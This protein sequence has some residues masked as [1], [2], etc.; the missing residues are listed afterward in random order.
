VKRLGGLLVEALRMALAQP[1]ATAVTS[2]IVAAACG[3]ILSTTGQTVAI[4]RDVLGRIDDAGTRT[5]V[6]EDTEGRADLDQGVVQRIEALAGV[7]W[8]VGFSVTR[9]AR[10]AGIGGGAAVPIRGLV[11][12]LPT[13]VSTT[14]WDRRPG[15]ALAGVDALAALGFATAAGPVQPVAVDE[16]QLA[17]VGRLSADAPLDFLNRGLLTVVAPDE[18]VMRIIVLAESTQDVPELADGIREVLDPADP[19]SVAIQ[20]SDALL[21]VRAAVRGELG[22]WGRNLVTVVLGAGLVLTALNVFGAVTARRRDFGRRRALGASRTDVLLLVTAQTVATAVAGAALG[23]AAGMAVV[24]QLI[25]TS[26]QFEFGAAIAVLA[27]IATAIA[28]LPPAIVAAY[29]D[30]VRILRVP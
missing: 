17:V 23:V 13:T 19:A 29:R 8:A 11:G 1:I 4:E 2:V 16:P 21:Q 6:V 20:T 27:V 9:D 30:P 24:L 5:I 28:A 26:P 22:I 14:S 25:G 7:D 12:E 3:V 10:P 15:A 18:H